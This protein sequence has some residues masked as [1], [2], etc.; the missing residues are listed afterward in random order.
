MSG[1][2]GAPTLGANLTLMQSGRRSIG[3]LLW[4]ACRTVRTATTYQAPPPH[5][6]HLHRV[7]TGDDW[8]ERRP[9][10]ARGVVHLSVHLN[11]LNARGL[12]SKVPLMRSVFV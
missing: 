1:N 6:F 2:E 4:I 8:G 7:E 12:P 11:A 5:R 9:T 10:L 3:P